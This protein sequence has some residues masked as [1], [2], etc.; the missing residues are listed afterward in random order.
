MVGRHDTDHVNVIAIED[1]SIVAVCIGL[2]LSDAIVVLGSVSVTRIDIANRDDIAEI[3]MPSGIPRAHAA[4]PNAPDDV[5]VIL[6]DVGKS[7]WTPTEKRH[8]ASSGG[9]YRRLLQEVTT[10]RLIPFHLSSSFLGWF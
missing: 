3:R 5:S 10:T 6:G 1:P 7:L 4:N 8:S 9:Q 2:P